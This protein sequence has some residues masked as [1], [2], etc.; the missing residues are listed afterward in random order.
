MNIKGKYLKDNK[1]NE[2]F[3]PITSA[4]SVLDSEGIVLGEQIKEII[5]SLDIIN[6][7]E[8]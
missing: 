6:G 1:T 2:K 4:Y 7:E 5:T 8:I 3:S